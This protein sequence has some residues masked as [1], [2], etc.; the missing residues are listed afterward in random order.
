MSFADAMRASFGVLAVAST[1][2]LCLALLPP[3]APGFHA[4]RAWPA[5]WAASHLLGTIALVAQLLLLR[6]MDVEPSLWIVLAPW[7]LVLLAR[8]ITL[9]GAMVPRH[10]PRSEIAGLGA[11]GV[12]ILALSISILPWITAPQE[13]AADSARVDSAARRMIELMSGSSAPHAWRLFQGASVIALLVITSFGLARARRAPLERNVILLLLAALIASK[14]RALL[15]GTDVCIALCLG[16]GAAFTIPWLRRADR[17]AAQLAVIAFAGATLV[18]VRAFALSL[19]GLF[20]LCALTP[21]VSR[22]SVVIASLI[23]YPIAFVLG[24]SASPGWGLWPASYAREH[25]RDAILWLIL[26]TAGLTLL[27]LLASKLLARSERETAVA[28]DAPRRELTASI[29]ILVLCAFASVWRP[30]NAW[31]EPARAEDIVHAALLP[32]APIAALVIGLAVAR[33]ERPF[34][35][36]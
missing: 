31:I 6:A 32:L 11:R 14:A 19:S 28:I 10:E 35:E 36:R 7:S 27:G 1:G 20:A 34:R 5:T 21:S 9:P 4:L 3:G 33:A 15:D 12:Q 13:E 17:R 23:A 24:A 8:W 16:A 26:W 2:R 22:A 30:T 18:D 29:V 25:M